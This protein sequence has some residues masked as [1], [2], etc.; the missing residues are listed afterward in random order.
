MRDDEKLEITA[1][2]IRKLAEYYEGVKWTF[3]EVFKEE[4]RWETLKDIQLVRGGVE[5]ITVLVY[6]E[7][8]HIATIWGSGRV[9]TWP[10]NVRNV[11]T[12]NYFRFERRILPCPK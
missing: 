6:W 4:E 9:S 8:I 10:D 5:G 12:E 3:P 11:S 2:Q 7:D 1:G